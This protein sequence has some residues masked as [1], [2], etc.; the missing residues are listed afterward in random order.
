MPQN[1][2]THSIQVAQAAEQVEAW[3]EQFDPD[4]DDVEVDDTRDLAA[5]A[6]AADAVAAAEAALRTAVEV[7]RAHG[8]SWN[9]IAIPL[10]VSRQAALQRFGEPGEPRPAKK[11]AGPAKTAKAK[12]TAPAR[13]RQ[14]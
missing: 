9:R 8:R 6:A 4:G 10:G 7:A 13:R 5:V 14:A 3:A 12:R 11:K 2:T 1:P